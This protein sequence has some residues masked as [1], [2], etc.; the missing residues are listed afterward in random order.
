MIHYM[1]TYNAHNKELVEKINDVCND[2]DY[3]PIVV[4]AVRAICETC[5]AECMEKIGFAPYYEDDIMRNLSDILMCVCDDTDL[6]I[7]LKFCRKL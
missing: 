4:I 1:N 6:E 5:K 3:L 2:E 7:I